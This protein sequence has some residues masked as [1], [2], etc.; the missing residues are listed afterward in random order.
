[1]NCVSGVSAIEFAL[2]APLLISL[3][4]CGAE[5]E[6]AVIVLR[7][8]TDMSHT[9]ANLTTQ[10]ETMTTDDASLVLAAT[11]LVMNPYSTST[12][13]LIVSEI[14]VGSG[15]TGTVVWSCGLNRTP[16]ALNSTVT[17][18]STTNSDTTSYLIYGESWYTYTPVVIS[19][20]IPGFAI[21]DL[22]MYESLYMVPRQSTSIPLTIGTGSS[23]VTCNYPSS[24]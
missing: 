20:V 15:G 16:R 23:D 24:S 8:V 17:V 14:S 10:Y 9:V 6:D 5:I 19:T 21:P 1:M 4:I 18:P 7:K 22:P 12:A 2:I 13:E 11:L 3:F